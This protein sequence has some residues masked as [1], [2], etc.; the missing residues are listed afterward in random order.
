MYLHANAKLG[1]A[2]RS[3]LV[4]AIESGM[5]LKATAAAFNVSPATVHRWWHRWREAGEEARRTRSCLLDRSSLPHRSP[6]R[7]APELEEAIRRCRRQTG[8]GPRLVAGATGFAH[9]TVWKVLRRAGISRPRLSLTSTTQPALPHWLDHY[10]RQR[11]HSSLGGR[12]PISRVHN[13]C[14]QDSYSVPTSS[15]TLPRFPRPATRSN[16]APASVSGKTES[17][18]ARSS[19]ASTSV[20]NSSS[21]S[22][23]GSTMK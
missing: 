4:T 14:G 3:A 22:W 9:S 15:T 12:P 7:L 6:R 23:S 20:L 18:S 2:G 19:P 17:T 1:L 21:C 10:N 5:T 11:P 13:V 8:W 16:A